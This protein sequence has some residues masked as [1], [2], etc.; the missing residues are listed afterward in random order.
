MYTIFK[1]VITRMQT[2]TTLRI[3]TITYEKIAKLA[4]N[5]NRSIN[6]QICYILKEYLEMMKWNNKK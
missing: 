5:E 3:D 6:Q 2:T 4:Q 1:E